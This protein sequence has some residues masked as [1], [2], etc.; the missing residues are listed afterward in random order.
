MKIVSLKIISV[1]VFLF[2]ISLGS[3]FAEVHV[4]G[5][6]RSNGTYVA[7]HTRSSPSSGG[8]SSG[9]TSHSSQPSS[10]NFTPLIT[11]NVPKP[12]VESPVKYRFSKKIPSTYYYTSGYFGSRD[13]NGR[14]VRS[15]SAKRDFMKQTGYPHG[16][17]GYVVD[18]IVALKRGGADNPSNMQWQ[19][20][21]QGKAKD[22]WE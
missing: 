5:Y 20:I 16:R 21:A 9:S 6:T 12:R 17:P 15:E 11:G 1:S 19:T 22:K 10:T 14:I 4:R 13:S 2:A 7:P 18:H 8:N 3:I